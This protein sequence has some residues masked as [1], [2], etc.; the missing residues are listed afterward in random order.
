MK[1]HELAEVFQTIADLLDIRGEVVYKIV[2]YRRAAERLAELD[3]DVE[4]LWQTGELTSIPGIGKAIAAK[5]DEYLRT[6]E[7]EFLKRLQ[8]EVPPTLR[9]W[10][11]VP[12]LG[13]K[14]IGLVWRELGITT[15]EE[16][17]AAAREGRLRELKGM[18]ARTEANI[19]AGIQALRRRTNR[20]PLEIAW[21]LMD[22]LRADLLR[23][24]GVARVEPAGS[25][26]RGRDTV[27]DLD[28][29]VATDDPAA[30]AAALRE[31]PL[32][33]EVLAQGETKT[34]LR[35]DGNMRAQV[36][37]YPPRRFGTAWQYAT[38]SQ[39]HN[40][41]LRELAR[42]RGFSLTDGALR[43]L[44]ETTEVLCAEEHEVYAALGL[45][46]IPPELREDHGEVETALEGHLPELLRENELKSELHAHS[47]WSDGRV[48]IR[49]LAEAAIA[50]GLRLLAI[51]DHSQSLGVASGL[52]VDDLRRQR[53]EI[54][55]VQR[56]LGDRIR[57]L[58]GI[59]VEI[60]ADGSL[61]FP[62]EV[63]AELDVVIASLHTG[64]R[65]PRERVTARLLNAIRNPHVDIIGHPTGRLIPN[66]EGA[67]LDMDAVLQAAAE[68]GVALEINANPR[69]LDL[70][71]VYVRRAIRMGIPVAVNTDAHTP[72]D[73]DLRPFG[74]RTARRGWAEARQVLNAWPVEHLERWLRE[75]T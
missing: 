28:L 43:H 74:V 22:R 42:K 49:E 73:L 71:D 35:L 2:A 72:D 21:P 9:E 50:R 14:K 60:R 44:D 64:L 75:R 68:H 33:Q 6:G 47:T 3:T 8:T 4:T 29:V 25:L 26:R 7:L 13:P 58:Q 54:R 40:V 55:A 32:V 62:D 63:L 69:R 23:V 51:T 57:L 12:G 45:P 34:S 10:L 65:Q 37:T 53:E 15:L 18:G 27:G 17:E 52:S 66:R 1:N 59:E 24:P 61:D 41:R 20:L 70:P 19:L 11:Q 5:I 30:V 39:A 56:A 38:G 48:G 16:L 67:D 31:H 36:W 46:W